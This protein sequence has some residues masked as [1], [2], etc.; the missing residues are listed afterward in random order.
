MLSVFIWCAGDQ[1]AFTPVIYIYNMSCVNI[2]IRPFADCRAN[3][4][5]IIYKNNTYK[6]FLSAFYLCDFLSFLV[7]TNGV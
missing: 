7:F 2:S 1:L 6:S 3:D 4:V 5:E